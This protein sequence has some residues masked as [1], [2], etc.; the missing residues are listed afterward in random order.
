MI[1]P[2]LL[3]RRALHALLLR[4]IGTSFVCRDPGVPSFNL[5]LL[6]PLLP[7]ISFSPGVVP[8]PDRRRRG[9]AEPLG[10]FTNSFLSLTSGARVLARRAEGPPVAPE[11]L[12][13]R[14]RNG[15]TEKGVREMRIIALSQSTVTLFPELSAA[16]FSRAELLCERANGPIH[17]M[18][19]F[20]RL[21]S[22]LSLDTSMRHGRQLERSKRAQ[23]VPFSHHSPG[24]RSSWLLRVV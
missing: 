11:R 22:D 24:R 21:P 17:C 16:L 19:A 15:R 1:M 23:A 13:S 3:H 5:P 14:E 18:R 9:E 8:C 7:P 12:T 20:T 6:L 10:K 4:R 2:S